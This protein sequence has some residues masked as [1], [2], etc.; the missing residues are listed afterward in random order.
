MQRTAAPISST[1]ASNAV[2][3]LR[4]MSRTQSFEEATTAP[5]GMLRGYTRIE[6][7]EKDGRTLYVYQANGSEHCVEIAVA[8]GAIVEIQ[9]VPPERAWEIALD[10]DRQ[11]RPGMIYD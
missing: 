9:P 3:G 10:R 8:E 6:R 1:R 7:L 5:D 4:S 11:F 2:A